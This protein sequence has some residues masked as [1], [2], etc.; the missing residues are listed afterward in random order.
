[1]NKKL[2]VIALIVMLVM[3]INVVGSV[4]AS[5]AIDADQGTVGQPQEPEQQGT[6]DNQNNL[7]GEKSSEVQTPPEATPGDETPAEGDEPTGEGEG[8]ETP[9]TP[10]VAP[11]WVEG[12]IEVDPEATSVD[13]I[14]LV[15]NADDILAA[16]G[17]ITGGEITEAEDGSKS[18]YVLIT[19]ENGAVV[20]DNT[21]EVVT[22][23]GEEPGD[24]EAPGEEDREPVPEEATDS[25]DVDVIGDLKAKMNI[26]FYAFNIKPVQAV[27]IKDSNDI[28]V[29]QEMNILI[30]MIKPDPIF[31][32]RYN[33]YG[34]SYGAVTTIPKTGDATSLISLLG[35]TLSGVG[36]AFLRKQR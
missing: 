29:K 6:Q 31:V 27:T 12:P 26:R 32:E 9:T 33:Y 4:F 18:I 24:S 8:D 28:V 15:V 36:I 20:D 13:P 16:G 2:L 30:N 17:E 14:T 7:D 5:E 34:Y 23:P 19:F 22:T 35:L 21:F 10:P 25:I 1:M 11:D 3:S